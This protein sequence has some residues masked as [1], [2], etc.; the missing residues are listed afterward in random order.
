[1]LHY[2]VG[3]ILRHKTKKNQYLLILTVNKLA[4]T[5][6]TY[7]ADIYTVEE[8]AGYQDDYSDAKI[9]K[10]YRAT[11]ALEKKIFSLIKESGCGCNGLS[12]HNE[13]KMFRVLCGVDDE[14]VFNIT[15]RTGAERKIWFTGTKL[16][17]G[18]KHILNKHYLGAVG[19][20]T[21]SDLMF[22]INVLKRGEVSSDGDKLTF[23]YKVA[24]QKKS[25]RLNCILKKNKY[26]G[27]GLVL[28]TYYS[29]RRG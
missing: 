14:C 20:L 29:N 1:M 4:P 10:N 16:D 19:H 18:A 5:N 12:D 27:V 23:I 8:G 28:V 25:Y 6:K 22:M 3:D 11:T 17:C 15:D 9:T 21:Y 24:Y 2:K 13:K 7:M 26:G